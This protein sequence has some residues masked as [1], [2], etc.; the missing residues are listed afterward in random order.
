MNLN[1]YNRKFPVFQRRPSPPKG[2]LCSQPFVLAVIF[3]SS[4]F[5]IEVK[6]C[7]VHYRGTY[8]LPSHY[9][10]N[11]FLPCTW[12][13]YAP[14]SCPSCAYIHVYLHLGEMWN[15]MS[16]S[17]EAETYHHLAKNL[18]RFDYILAKVVKMSTLPP[19]SPFFSTHK[20]ATQI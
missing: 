1:Y 7:I 5:S 9:V 2:D 15:F 3:S 12:Q 14:S 17:N 8:W 11:M 6:L 16:R 19:S 20:G 13:T 10:W 4:L 18:R